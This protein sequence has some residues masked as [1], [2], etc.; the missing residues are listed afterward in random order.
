MGTVIPFPVRKRVYG[1]YDLVQLA[2]DHDIEVD[3]MEARDLRVIYIL[4][5]RELRIAGV[6]D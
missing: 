2:I 1:L 4:Y 3:T 5:K 6:L